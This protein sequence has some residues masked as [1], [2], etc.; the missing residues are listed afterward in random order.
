MEDCITY[1]AA[2]QLYNKSTELNEEGI[3][4]LDELNICYYYE[5]QNTEIQCYLNQAS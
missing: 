1:T 5:I 3:A 4:F 2:M